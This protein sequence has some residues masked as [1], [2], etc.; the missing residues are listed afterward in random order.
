MNYSTPKY[1]TALNHECDH[2]L[3]TALCFALP[4]DGQLPEWVELIPAPGTN[5]RIDGRDGR[6]WFMN[7]VQSIINQ[8]L[9]Q[10]RDIVG[11]Y[12]HASEL[13]APKGEEA[14]AAFWIKQLDARDGAIWGRIEWT[15]RGEASVRNKEYRY[16][17]PVFD[18]HRTTLAIYRLKSVGLTNKHNLYLPALNQEQTQPNQPEETP[19]LLSEAVRKA[20]GLKEGSTEDDATA[21]IAARNQELQTAKSDL[22]TAKNNQQQPSLDKFVPRNDYDTAMNRASDAE[23]KLQDHL[24]TAKNQEVTSLV[25]QAIEQGKITP[26]NKDFYISAC[27]QE[28]GVES[29]KKFIEAAPII[30]DDSGLDNKKPNDENNT[31]LN[32]EQKQVANMFGNSI[33]DLN[34]YGK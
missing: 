10:Q 23:T 17:S 14:P 8:S 32:A 9:N 34:K 24:S 26:A 21:F 33:E 6:H 22:A 15:P 7:D 31:A 4:T 11:D 18:Y 1:Q 3:S 12:E 16:L 30:A 29:F 25:D 2:E 28:N 27:N 19:M 20:L 13:K 5:A